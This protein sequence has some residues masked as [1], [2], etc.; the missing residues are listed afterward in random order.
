MDVNP[1]IELVTEETAKTKS[2]FLKELKE[3]FKKISWTSQEDLKLATKVVVGSI[4]VLGIAI[5]MTDLTI[6][7]GLFLIRTL[8]IWMG[9]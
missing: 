2:S 5:Y 6:K 1:K 7:G 3:E 4:F 8:A 9:A